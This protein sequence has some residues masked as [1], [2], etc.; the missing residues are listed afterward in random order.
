MQK[1]CVGP[2]VL[3]LAAVG[4]GQTIN[5]TCT[6]YPTTAYCTSTSSGA[7]IAEVLPVLVT[8]RCIGA[9][10]RSV[11]YISPPRYGSGVKKVPKSGPGKPKKCTR[12][13]PEFG[14]SSDFVHSGGLQNQ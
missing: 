9:T 4:F 6:L 1:V 8:G 13:V 11:P 10:S 3:L 2:L 14:D 7:S 5:T 12:R